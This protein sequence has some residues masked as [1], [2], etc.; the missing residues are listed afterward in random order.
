MIYYVTMPILKCRTLKPNIKGP[1]LVITQAIKVKK[2]LNVYSDIYFSYWSI[3]I[4][5]NI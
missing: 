2:C 3:I 4:E 5:F 1:Y